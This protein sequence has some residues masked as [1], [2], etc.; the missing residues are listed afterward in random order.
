MLSTRSLS[1]LVPYAA[2]VLAQSHFSVTNVAG[3]FLQD[4]SSTD[5]STF[6]YVSHPALLR[7]GGPC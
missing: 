5:P 1:L 2:A 7:V 6:N 4:D 3:Y